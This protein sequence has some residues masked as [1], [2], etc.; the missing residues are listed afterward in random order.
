M[1]FSS[2]EFLGVFLPLFLLAYYFTWK[3]ARPLR[4]TV[5]FLFSI[6]FYAYGA[7]VSGTPL[8][9]LLL[10]VSVIYNFAVGKELSRLGKRQEPPKGRMKA[11]LAFGIVIDFG[12]LFLFKYADFVFGVSLGLALPIGISFYTFQIVSYI[13]D[14]YRE[15]RLVE[16]SFVNLGAY[17]MM[18]PQLIAGPIVRFSTVR[19]DLR[20]RVENKERFLDGVKTF[21]I[22]LGFKVIIAN[23]LGSTWTQANTIGFESLSVPMAWLSM[24]A[25]SFQLF[26]D[27]YGYSLMAIGLGRMMGFE[28]PQNFDSPYISVSMTEFWRR[29][30]MTL[31]TWFREYVY[32]PLGGNRCGKG[33]GIFNLFVVWMLTGFWHGADWNFIIWGLFLFAVITIERQGVRDYMESHRFIG[34]IYM[35]L[36]IPLQW[37][38]FAVSDLKKLGALYGRLIGIGGVAVS[39]SDWLTELS[40]IWWI[41]LVAL[42]LSTD[43]GKKLYAKVKDKW[44]VWIPLAGILAAVIYCLAMGLNDPF[45]YFRF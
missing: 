1:V 25:Y 10:F 37:M 16:N 4:N 15:P 5:I 2:F 9:I 40:H 8:Y 26:F 21:I 33:R 29:W 3:Y 45:L 28:F 14:V 43:L 32:I 30:H 31:G 6:G 7:I 39:G 34:H 38:V 41:L 12:I 19:T 24:I 27:F 35:I 42:V 18:F 22:G 44:F 11:V 17:I 13:I 23:Q 36:L 20:K